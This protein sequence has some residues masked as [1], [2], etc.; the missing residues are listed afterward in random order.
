[1]AQEAYKAGL[2]AQQRQL[3]PSNAIG[4]PR[5]EERR[6]DRARSMSER[7]ADPGFRKKEAAPLLPG[8]RI[9]PACNFHNFRGKL[10]TRMRVGSVHSFHLSSALSRLPAMTL[11]GTC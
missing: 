10:G 7:R 4:E 11:A 8:D 3:R 5:Y 6:G 2:A 9:C 1:M